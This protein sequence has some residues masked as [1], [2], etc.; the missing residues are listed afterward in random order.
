MGISNF[1][2]KPIKQLR[3][4]IHGYM[5][6]NEGAI[7]K[8]RPF[9]NSAG[10]LSDGL[11]TRKDLS[12]KFCSKPWEWFEVVSTGSVGVCC[13][14]W[15]KKSIGNCL[16]S[17]DIMTIWNSPAAQEIRGSIQDGSF[18][19][20]NQEA[21][22]FIQNDTL[23]DKQNITDKR[24]RR[25]LAEGIV[26]VEDFPMTIGLVYDESC[27]LRCPSC[28]QELL[29]FKE[30]ARY[31]KALKIHHTIESSLFSKPHD[32]HIEL[33]MTG[34]GDP[35]A[36]PIFRDLLYSLNGADF[37]NLVINL[38]T[39]GVLFTRS[40]EKMKKLHHNIGNVIV[41]FDAAT[42]E[43][44]AYTRRGGNWNQ[45][46]KNFE[47]MNE[48]RRSGFIRKLEMDFVIQQK[49]YREM[50]DFINLGKEYGNVDTVGFSL[51]TNWGTYS[52]NEFKHH[53]IWRK[54]HPEFNDF[55]DILKD[56]IFDDPIVDL[57]NVKEYRARS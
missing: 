17:N 26:I 8:A 10:Q 52:P 5:R 36:S 11:G 51:I 19:Y 45:L 30:G 49:N 16:Y 31:E 13:S 47:F 4:K 56:P 27:N 7:A 25:I 21:C 28:R 2:P 46:L 40:W 48:L 34:S 1:I 3:W 50:A 44:Y 57:K 29:Y 38:V 33:Y 6:G 14:D 15:L 20:C 12:R 35:F 22:H 24:F 32:K 9:P 39:N 54:D 42:P 37:P 41:S 18:R 55:L 53:A 23:P 43:T